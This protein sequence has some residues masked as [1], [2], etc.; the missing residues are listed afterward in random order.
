[1]IKHVFY[2]IL[3][4]VESVVLSIIQRRLSMAGRYSPIN[5]IIF[6]HIS[7]KNTKIAK[8]DWRWNLETI[9]LIDS[10]NKHP[11]IHLSRI[12]INKNDAIRMKKACV[13]TDHTRLEIIANKLPQKHYLLP[14][15]AKNLLIT[16]F[17]LLFLILKFLNFLINLPLIFDLFDIFVRPVSPKIFCLL[18]LMSV[19]ILLHLSNFFLHEQL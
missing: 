5:W 11:Y 17:T 10:Q 3:F 9:D 13:H 12:N 19:W 18:S 16:N 14:I 8:S 15:I 7:Y 4:A 2:R 1:M 6:C